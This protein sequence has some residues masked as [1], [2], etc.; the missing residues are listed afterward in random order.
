MR[1]RRARCAAILPAL[2]CGL[3]LFAATATAASE[4]G[5]PHQLAA[6]AAGSALGESVS[7]S[8]DGTIAVVG[9]PNA[10]GG[11]GAVAVYVYDNVAKFWNLKNRL[12]PTGEHGAG[13]FGAAVSLDPGGQVLIAGAP[14]DNGGIGA[15][16]TFTSSGGDWSQ[17]AALTADAAEV[18]PGRFGASVA[19]AS[20]G[21]LALIGAPLS[22]AGQGRAFTFDY[23]SIANTWTEQ[24]VDGHPQASEPEH[25]GASVALDN[26][27]SIALVGAPGANS[28]SGAAFPFRH[29][30]EYVE[31]LPGDEVQSPAYGGGFGTSVALSF[32]GQDQLIGAPLANGG[33]GAAYAYGNDLGTFVDPSPSNG[34]GFGTSV[35]V[36][37]G[38]AISRVLVG[39]PGD[40]GGA[41]AVYGFDAA[42]GVNWMSDGMALTPGAAPASGDGYGMS[43]AISQDASTA[44][45]GSPAASAGAGGATVFTATAS[46]APGTPTSVQAVAG[47]GSAAVSWNAPASDGG[48]PITG[49]IVT[50]SPGGQTCTTAIALSCTVNGLTNGVTYTFGVTATNQIGNSAPSAASSPAIPQAVGGGGGGSGGPGGGGS[51]GGGSGGGGG[52]TGGSGSGGAGGDGSSSNGSSSGSGPGGGT[53]G[54]STGGKTRSLG[55]GTSTWALPGRPAG[56]LHAVLSRA[57]IVLSWGAP[58]YGHAI[59]GYRIY[60]SLG[61]L[62]RS[63]A[64]TPARVRTL[65]RSGLHRGRRYQFAVRAFDA[66]GQLSPPLTRAPVTVR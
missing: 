40:G 18:G 61:G 35:A 16:W 14:D 27:G 62:W 51:G 39:A 64:V 22:N 20:G 63:L 55:P 37:G 43:A 31:W 4:F 1:R 23:D 9:E 2:Y 7:V 38:F 11:A 32:T 65:V 26:N 6:D 46:T 57:S 45:V 47:D 60:V 13:H 33:A 66:A 34:G 12:Q 5:S 53:A 49:Y 44:L 17:Q 59:A 54:G 48:S 56:P 8:A 52:S 58:R 29:F 15:A 30:W 41:G 50:S 28:G 25:F 19:I 36:D 24:D 42:N 10:D 21:S 3:A